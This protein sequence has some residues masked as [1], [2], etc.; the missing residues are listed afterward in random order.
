MFMISSEVRQWLNQGQAR[1]RETVNAA[2]DCRMS[3]A[4]TLLVPALI[5][6]IGSTRIWVFGSV[7]RREATENSDIDIFVECDGTVAQLPWSKRQDAISDLLKMVRKQ[8][9]TWGCDIIVWSTEEVRLGTK[10]SE[11]MIETIKKEGVLIYE[12]PGKNTAVHSVV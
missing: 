8:G 4:K 6:R 9:F 10:I 12:R 7:A 1:I 2:S 5:K 11:P 3:A